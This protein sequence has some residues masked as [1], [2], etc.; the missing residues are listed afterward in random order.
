M[1]VTTV[2]VYNIPPNVH[3]RWLGRVF[4]RFGNV[5]DVF[6][7]RK[8]DCRGNVIGFV[9]FASLDEAKKA[10][11]NLN[12]VWFFYHKIGVNLARFNPRDNY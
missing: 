5:F 1:V 9:R 10:Q 4:Q 8:R 3:W 12:G 2:F 7:P 11:W 6:I